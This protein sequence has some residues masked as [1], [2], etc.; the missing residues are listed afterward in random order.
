MNFELFILI[1]WIAVFA[2]TGTLEFSRILKAIRWRKSLG[3]Q[4]TWRV[5][6]SRLGYFVEW[7]E[8]A[9]QR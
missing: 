8:K 3:T 5:K 6:K 7:V 2:I 9:D 4:L 1:L